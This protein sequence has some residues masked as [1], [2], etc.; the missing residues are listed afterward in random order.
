MPASGS[1]NLV[2]EILFRLKRAEPAI[3]REPVKGKSFFRATN[4]HRLGIPVPVCRRFGKFHARF[5]TTWQSAL[6]RRSLSLSTRNK[7]SSSVAS[8]RLRISRYETESRTA[9]SQFNFLFDVPNI[10]WQLAHASDETGRLNQVRRAALKAF[11]GSPLQH[12]PKDLY[13]VY[14]NK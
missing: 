6:R 13:Y 1:T 11:A 7:K 9:P 2:Q 3:A 8:A 10:R 4:R 12:R 5:N 14:D